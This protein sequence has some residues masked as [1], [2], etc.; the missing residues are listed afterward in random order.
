LSSVSFI[1]SC[2]LAI[3][4]HFLWFSY[5]SHIIRESRQYYHRHALP[6]V[7]SF[8]DI[9]TFFGIF[10]WLAPLFLFLSLSAN[11]HA[12]PTSGSGQSTFLYPLTSF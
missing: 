12:L 7:P 2:V 5:F 6:P 10:V 11:D 1:S 9:T 4:D 8:L 3:L